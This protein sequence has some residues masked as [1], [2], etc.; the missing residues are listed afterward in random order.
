M[1]CLMAAKYL[2]GKI[3]RPDRHI[4]QVVTLKKLFYGFPSPPFVNIQRQQ[5]V[6]TVV[7]PR[8]S[9]KQRSDVLFLG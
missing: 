9:V 6:K 4:K 5:V 7:M 1:T 3:R 2:N 8:D